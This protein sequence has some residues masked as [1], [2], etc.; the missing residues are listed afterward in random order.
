MPDILSKY[1]NLKLRLFLNTKL[2]VIIYMNENQLN[3][4][5]TRQMQSV[6]I[7]CLFNFKKIRIEYI[8]IISMLLNKYKK[9]LL[10]ITFLCFNYLLGLK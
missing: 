2:K 10:V 8:R 9:K 5:F 6:F 4:L 3:I 7:D 1:L